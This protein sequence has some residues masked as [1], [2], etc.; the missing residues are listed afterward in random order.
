MS[1]FLF[2]T[3]PPPHQPSQ[4]MWGGVA[5]NVVPNGIEIGLS[6]SDATYSV[7]YASRLVPKAPNA[8]EQAKLVEDGVLDMITTFSR[9]HM[10]KFLGVGVTVSLVSPPRDLS[11]PQHNL[12]NILSS[13]KVPTFALLYGS[14]SISSP[15]HSISARTPKSPSQS[16]ISST[17][18]PKTSP[19]LLRALTP[20]SKNRKLP[21]SST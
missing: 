15:L 14:I 4:P 7:D 20:P 12:S 9:E 11:P 21:R 3:R 10:C 19:S 13:K 5:C 17:R 18:P 6:I 1:S 8:K 16:P 2:K